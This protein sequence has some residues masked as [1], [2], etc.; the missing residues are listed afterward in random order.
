VGKHYVSLSNRD[1]PKTIDVRWLHNIFFGDT[2]YQECSA[3]HSWYLEATP[4]LMTHIAEAAEALIAGEG[5]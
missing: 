2:Y 4:E 5:V 1:P 3:E